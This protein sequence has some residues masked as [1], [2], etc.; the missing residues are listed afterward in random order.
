MPIFK[1][2]MCGGTLEIKE[3]MSVAE[4]EYCGVKQTI[5]KTDD[6]KRRNLYERA[7]RF[8]RNA[9]FDKAMSIYKR[10][11][12]EDETDAEAYWS[13]ILC[14]YGI[15]YVEDEE[16]HK[17]I[18]AINRTQYTSV[19]AD[20]DYKSAIKYADEN[21]KELYEQEAK[22]IDEIQKSIL[23]IAIKEETFDIFICYKEKD[24]NGKRTLDSVLGKEIYR[25]LTAEGFKVFFARITLEDKLGINYEPYIFAALNSAKIMIV[26]GT[27][28][29]YFHAAWVKNEWSRYL[30]FIEKDSG[31]LLIPAYR[32]MSIYDLPKEFVHLQALNMNKP[33]FIMDLMQKIR[34]NITPRIAKEEYMKIHGQPIISNDKFSSL[35]KRAFMFLDDGQWQLAGEYFDKCLDINPESAEAYIG[36]LLSE[37]HM[38]NE[39]ELLNSKTP[40]LFLYSYEKALEFAKPEYR[41]TL[42]YYNTESIYRRGKRKMESAQGDYDYRTAI[43]IFETIPDYKDAKALIQKCKEECVLLAKEVVYAKAMELASSKLTS[44]VRKAINELS[45]IKDY[46]DSE[47]KIAELQ[48]IRKSILRSIKVAVVLACISVVIVFIGVN[49][50]IRESNRK[51]VERQILG[52]NYRSGDKTVRFYCDGT[53]I[54]RNDEEVFSRTYQVEGT[55][56]GANIVNENGKVIY[57]VKFNDK[58]YIDEITSAQGM[59][60]KRRWW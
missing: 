13:V 57:T 59:V 21:Q 3:G 22:V 31:K 40:L 53:Y 32:E 12:E 8:R 23:E 41:K 47:E 19:F 24:T 36:H 42:E 10:I 30:T 27:K 43:R 34:E 52:V 58:S 7:N 17:I 39:E 54:W 11:L 9:E 44:N 4:C 29:E 6:E 55:F 45:K 35:F 38:R 2:K 25:Q 50:M 51:T 37:L 14:R 56:T 26:L 48:N 5:P 1:C 18:P 46:K 49:G 15:E 28:S 60:Y 20:E 33:D 16:T